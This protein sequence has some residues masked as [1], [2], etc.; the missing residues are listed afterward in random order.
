MSSAPAAWAA[1]PMR[2]TSSSTPRWLGW[3]SST[4]A[5]SPRSSGPAVRPPARGASRISRRGPHSVRITSRTAGRTPAHPHQRAP[6]GGRG[7]VH[8]LHG[9]RGAVVEGGVGH[10]HAGDAA[11]HRL[12]L[13][14]GLEDALGQLRLV[15]GVRGHEL[16]AAGQRPYRGGDVVLVGTAAGEAHELPRS[17]GGAGGPVAAGQP[18]QPVEDVGLGRR[19]GFR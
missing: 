6:G 12:V 14:Q 1:P 4:A 19:S 2:A 8:P 7:Q 18:A 15:R 11:Q 16:A 13:E 10:V 9:G 17:R 3:A 5:G